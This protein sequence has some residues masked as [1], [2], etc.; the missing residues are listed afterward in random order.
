ME[1]NLNLLLGDVY[2]GG[3]IDQIAEDMTSL[4]IGVSA[5]ALSQ[6]AIEPAGN[7]KQSHIKVDLQANGRRKRIHR[8]EPHRI[9][10]C[11][12]NQHSLCITRD[13]L[14]G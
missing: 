2:V 3:H 8:K 14:L 6:E 4:S 10:K 1:A 9:R 7:H 5:H 12:F 13:E 11:V